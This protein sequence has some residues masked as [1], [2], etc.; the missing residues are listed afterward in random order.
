MLSPLCPYQPGPGVLRTDY[1]PMLLC[2]AL[3][4]IAPATTIR[5][6]SRESNTPATT[7]HNTVWKVQG[8][9]KPGTEKGI[10]CHYGGVTGQNPAT[11]ADFELRLLI[12]LFKLF[13]NSY[14]EQT[15]GS[16][17]LFT[18]NLSGPHWALGFLKRDGY[19]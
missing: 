16:V 4:A 19:S 1:S 15:G 10:T 11:S 12:T 6:A 2:D 18:D 5:G 3:E 8:G 13:I 17:L 9:W 7:L 14:T